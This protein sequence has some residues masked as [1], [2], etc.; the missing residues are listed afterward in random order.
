MYWSDYIGFWIDIGSRYFMIA[1]IAF[2]L[3][4]VLFKKEKPL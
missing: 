4:Y 1:G 3:F 2:L